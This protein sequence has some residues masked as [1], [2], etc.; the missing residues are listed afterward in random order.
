MNNDTGCMVVFVCMILLIM[1][2]FV[3]GVLSQDPFLRE[4]LS[5]GS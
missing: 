1:I 2:A 4:V 5:N 3:A